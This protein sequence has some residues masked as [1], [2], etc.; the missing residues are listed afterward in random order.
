MT[1]EVKDAEAVGGWRDATSDD[2]VSGTITNPQ[3]SKATWDDLK[4]GTYRVTEATADGWYSPTVTSAEFIIAK[5]TDSKDFTFTDTPFGKITAD[6][7]N[8]ATDTRM[9]GW[10][11][12][13]EVK[14]AEAV[15]GWRDATSDDLVSGTITNPQDSKATWDNLKLGTYRVTEAT[16]DGW[17]SPTV[18]SAEFIIAKATDSKD[19]TFT[20]TP[21][22]KITAD[23][24]NGATD[25]RMDGWS[26]TLE[27]RT[28]RR[29]AAGVTPPVTTW[30]AAPSPTPRTARRP[31]TTSSSAPTA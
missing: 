17:Y 20:N 12:T 18:T 25:T 27:S 9:D 14:D 10:S 6:K 4:L 5:A 23:K 26:M 30:S 11:M 24:I 29:W 3:D 19:F 31:R 7:I 22:G 8:G 13:L 16:A 2:L 15:G 28:P 1:L 21:F